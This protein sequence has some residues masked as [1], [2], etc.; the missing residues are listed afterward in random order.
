MGFPPHSVIFCLL[1]LLMACC[2]QAVKL[3]FMALHFESLS[4]CNVILEC[5]NAI[6]L[7]FYY[8]PAFGADHVVVMGV[9]VLVFKSGEAILKPTFLD[10]AGFSQKL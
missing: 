5:F 1:P 4:L 6:I 10:K 3:Q 9:W 2:T 8:C 7:E